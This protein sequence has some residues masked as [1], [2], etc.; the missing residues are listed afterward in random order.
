MEIILKILEYAIYGLL[1]VIAIMI[2]ILFY[3]KHMEVKFARQWAEEL[4]REA[5]L[6]KESHSL[7]K[8]ALIKEAQKWEKLATSHIISSSDPMPI[9]INRSNI[10]KIAVRYELEAGKTRDYATQKGIYEIMKAI[11]PFVITEFSSE[12]G[13]EI[14]YQDLYVATIENN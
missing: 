8:K 7:E 6:L 10:K 13:R 9:I 12:F 4:E 3:C 14:M 1:A 2:P 5:E 11:T